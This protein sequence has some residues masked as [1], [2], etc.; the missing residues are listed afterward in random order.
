MFQ[1]YSVIIQHLYIVLC[2]HH[3]KSS[4]LLSPFIPPVSSS[5]F[6]ILWEYMCLFKGVFMATGFDSYL[7]VLFPL[8]KRAQYLT[9]QMCALKTFPLCC[10]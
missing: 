6:L 5:T 7:L 9:A 1:V 2:V 4:L 10:K 3:P 8:T